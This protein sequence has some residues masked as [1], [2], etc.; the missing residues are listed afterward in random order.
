MAE[1]VLQIHDIDEAG[2]DYAFRISPQWLDASLAAD[3]LRSDPG[4]GEGA[5]AVHAQKNGAEYLVHGTLSAHLLADCVRCLGEAKVPVQVVVASLY[6][7]SDGHDTRDARDTRKRGGA[8][9]SPEEI[10]L[11]D[12]DDDDLQ[13]E[14]FSG[15]QLVLDDL[16]R[17]HLLLECPMQTLCSPDCAG[18]PVPAHVLPPEDVFGPSEGGVDPRLAPLLRLRDKVPPKKS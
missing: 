18:I 12:D 6:S 16:V 3:G 10:E 13:R 14:S 17:E 11:G 7:R 1:F 8:H 9:D 15:H 2:K 4:H 5:L